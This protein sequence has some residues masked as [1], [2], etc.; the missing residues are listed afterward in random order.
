[1][2]KPKAIEL[3]HCER[4]I[5]VHPEHCSGP[6][7]SNAIVRVYVHDG[8]SGCIRVEY[9][10]REEVSD[11]MHHLFSIG[12]VICRELI[13]AVPTAKMEQ[14]AAGAAEDEA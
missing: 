14:S 6:G 9:L 10:Q 12:E 4:I 8:A 2:K 11:A 3:N 13:A 7:W 5:A 1:M